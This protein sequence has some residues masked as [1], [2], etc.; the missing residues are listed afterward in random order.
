MKSQHAAARDR[1]LESLIAARKKSR[2]TQQALAKRLHKPQSFISKYERGQRDI[3][4]IE[5]VEIA[6]ALDMDAGRTVRDVQKRF[7]G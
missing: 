6:E 4:V 1:L 5:L 2:L 7:R 3:G